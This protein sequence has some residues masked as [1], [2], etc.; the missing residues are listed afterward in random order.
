MTYNIKFI[1]PE[2]I[3]DITMHSDSVNHPDI[4]VDRIRM[5]TDQNNWDMI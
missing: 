2:E 1:I 3:T 4:V 5:Q